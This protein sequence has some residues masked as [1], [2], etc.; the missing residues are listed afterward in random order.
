LK[1]DGHSIMS[2]TCA[3]DECNDKSK[4]FSPPHLTPEGATLTY[5]FTCI[6]NPGTPD[7][8]ECTLAGGS[9][10]EIQYEVVRGS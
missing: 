3:A 1:E 7:V 10:I 2:D 6:D 9:T 5:E 8:D 4:T